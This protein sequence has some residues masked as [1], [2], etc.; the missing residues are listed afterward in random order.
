MPSATFVVTVHWTHISG[1]FAS[2]DEI[3]SSIQDTLNDLD[4]SIDLSG[5]GPDSDTEYSVVGVDVEEQVAPT[6]LKK[7]PLSEVLAEKQTVEVVYIAGAYRVSAY[8]RLCS[9]TWEQRGPAEAYC[10]MIVRGQ[11]AP[12]FLDKGQR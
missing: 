4:S 9:P 8:G 12:E 1:K 5:I 3:V 2:R 7:K 11:R 6:K 10:D